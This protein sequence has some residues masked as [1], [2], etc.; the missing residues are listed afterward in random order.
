[1]VDPPFRGVSEPFQQMLNRLAGKFSI[2][3]DR[4]EDMVVGIEM[5]LGF[6]QQRPSHEVKVGEVR[7][8]SPLLEGLQKNLPLRNTDR[9]TGGSKPIE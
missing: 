6:D 4:S 5:S 8:D 1:M 9:Q 2:A 3:E 7:V